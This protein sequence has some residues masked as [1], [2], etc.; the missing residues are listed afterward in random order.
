M[1]KWKDDEEMNA[2]DKKTVSQK[3]RKELIRE[4]YNKAV[5]LNGNAL[6]KLSKN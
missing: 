3:S 6:E 1:K 2:V 5:R 4:S